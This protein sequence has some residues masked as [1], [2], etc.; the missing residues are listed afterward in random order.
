MSRIT[1][2]QSGSQILPNSLRRNP[3]SRE[4]RSDKRL[5]LRSFVVS[6]GHD[7]SPRTLVFLL[8]Y[9]TGNLFSERNVIFYSLPIPTPEGFFSPLHLPLC[10]SVSAPSL[11]VTQGSQALKST[12]CP[13][14]HPVPLS[15]PLQT[16]TG[17]SF[18]SERRMM[19]LV[20]RWKREEIVCIQHRILHNRKGGTWG[21]C[22]LI[23]TGVGLS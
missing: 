12:F 22:T 11:A 5:P 19:Q 15:C 3:Q 9:H 2:R 4:E 1:P 16:A 14:K 21:G 13:A 18:F 10:V 20:R 17:D 7:I 8:L 23:T 6:K